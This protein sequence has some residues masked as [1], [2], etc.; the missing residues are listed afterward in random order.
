LHQRY[1]PFT[2]GRGQSRGIGEE[3]QRT[4]GCDGKRDPFAANLR[5]LIGEPSALA[6]S[7]RLLARVGERAMSMVA[8]RVTASSDGTI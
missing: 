8:L 5:Q 1:L 2:D 3:G 6:R 4:F 7:E